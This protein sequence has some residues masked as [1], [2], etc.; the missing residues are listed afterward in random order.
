MRAA[1]DALSDDMQR[2]IDG[3]VAEHWALHSR[4]MLGDTDYTEAQM[5]T[6]PP[7]K[8]PIV[9]RHAGSGRKH[10]FIGVHCREVT[11]MTLPEGRVLLLDLLEHATQRAFVY[12]HV[13]RVGDLVMWDN[14]CVLHRGRH[15]DPT[16]RRELRRSTTDDLASVQVTAA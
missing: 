12:R 16:Q 15:F 11:G 6:I 3:L 2:Q 4:I 10:L 9:R 5:R 7:V 13:W 14:R 8:W 1:Y